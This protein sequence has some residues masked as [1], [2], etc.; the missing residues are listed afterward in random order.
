LRGIKLPNVNL[1]DL[2]VHRLA[3]GFYIHILIFLIFLV[4]LIC[5]IFQRTEML[6]ALNMHLNKDYILQGLP[7]FENKE[8]YC[9]LCIK[10]EI[11]HL[12]FFETLIYQ[13]KFELSVISSRLCQTALLK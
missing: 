2:K 12:H 11:D 13:A 1:A 4:G 8:P 6:F 7:F 10:L 9:A 5:I 3:Y